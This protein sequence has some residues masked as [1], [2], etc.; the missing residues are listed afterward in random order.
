MSSS[1][2]SIPGPQPTPLTR[3]ALRQHDKLIQT[4]IRQ[5]CCRRCDLSWW[6]VV[7]ATKPVSRCRNCHFKFDP[8]PRWYESGVGFFTCPNTDCQNVFYTAC[9]GDAYRECPTCFSMVGGPYIHPAIEPKPYYCQIWASQ[10]HISTGSTYDT[11]LSL[12]S[13]LPCDPFSSYREPQ[14][15]PPSLP[16]Q[17]RRQY[18]PLSLSQQDFADYSGRVTRYHATTS[19]GSA[20]HG[21]T[22]SSI[23]SSCLAR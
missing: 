2:Q 5:F 12:P 9:M 17:T 21:S 1:L 11:W 20:S 13:S 14:P 4:D 15:S 10:Y 8:L 22:N 3:K 23:G 19:C 7:P 18:N 16:R 6:R